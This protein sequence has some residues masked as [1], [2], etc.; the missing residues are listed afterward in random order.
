MLDA[1]IL[2]G[3]LGT[4]LRSVVSEL[5]KAMAPL[6]GKPFLEWVLR[7]LR[8]QGVQRVVLATGYKSSSIRSHFGACFEDLQLVYSE[9]QAPLGTGGA[10]CAALDRVQTDAAFVLNGDTFLDVDLAAVEARWR[11][12]GNPVIVVREVADTQRYG[13][14]VLDEHHVIR[15]FGEKTGSGPG[16]ISAGCYCFPRDMLAAWH[17]RGA[18]SLESDF[19]VPALQATRFEAWVAQ[20]RFI[21]IGVPDDYARALDV[22]QAPAPVATGH[23]PGAAPC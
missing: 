21:D 11:S 16:Y 17:G 23:T 14:V 15:G 10:L 9:E 12:S 7:D 2:A 1:V 18:F 13:C 5:P 20:G 3:G 6:G 4:R 8:R 19:I 22:I